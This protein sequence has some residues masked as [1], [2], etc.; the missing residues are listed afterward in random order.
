MQT[1]TARPPH[2]KR[3][4]SRQRFDHR[5]GALSYRPRKPFQLRHHAAEFLNEDAGAGLAQ[6]LDQTAVQPKRTIPAPLEAAPDR[7]AMLAEIGQDRA[8]VV[9]LVGR[10]NPDD[11]WPRVPQV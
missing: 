5:P 2:V 3:T 8:G 11:L 7:I 4:S 6:D 10:G 1:F 9:E